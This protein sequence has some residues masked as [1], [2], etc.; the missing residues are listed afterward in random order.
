MFS[1]KKRRVLVV[2]EISHIPSSVESLNARTFELVTLL[3]LLKTTQYERKTNI[4]V[5]SNCRRVL[6]LCTKDVYS[7]VK[8]ITIM[9]NNVSQAYK[10]IRYLLTTLLQYVL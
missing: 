5:K 4:K 10:T 6:V 3:E 9:I 8:Y 2:K 7:L 1:R